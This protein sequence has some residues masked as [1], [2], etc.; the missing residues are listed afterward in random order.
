MRS[1]PNHS[2]FQ[3][4]QKTTRPRIAHGYRPKFYTR[5]SKNREIVGV[6]A[7]QTKQVVDHRSENLND[8]Y[9]KEGPTS[10]EAGA[11]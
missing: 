7:E 4:E 1:S 5:F 10:T 3:T 2:Q 11:L 9:W 8:A 6:P